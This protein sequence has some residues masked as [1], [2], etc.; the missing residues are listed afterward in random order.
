MSPDIREQ[1]VVEIRSSPSRISLQLDESTDV[2]NF[3]QLL[4]FSRYIHEGDLKEEFLMC[5]SLASTTK[6]ID[7]FEK[8]KGFFEQN[9][10]T[11]DNV[12][13]LYRDGATAMSWVES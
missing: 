6:A 1:V 3:S 12:G 11:W 13:S 8:F 7:V 9:R 5:E 4:V 2:S 10:I